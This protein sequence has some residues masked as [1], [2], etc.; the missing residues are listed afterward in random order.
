[1]RLTRYRFGEFELDPAS[2]ELRRDGALLQVPLKSLECLAYLVEHRE[3]AVGRDELVSAV[4]GRADVSDTV[5]TQTMRRAR[6]AL[7]DAGNR[8]TVVRTVPGF[9]Y[10][11]VATTEVVEGGRPHPAVVPAADPAPI[12]YEPAAERVLPAPK[13]ATAHHPAPE[14]RGRGRRYGALAGGLFLIAAVVAAVAWWFVAGNH[15]TGAGAQADDGLVMVM[16]V[17]VEPADR[18][19]SWVRLGAMEYAA[20]R[21]RGAA[22]KVTPTEQ[23]L[24]L[25]AASKE[26]G[27]EP[28][29]GSQM[30]DAALREL[31]ASSGA[32]WLLVPRAQQEGGH[33]RVQLRALDRA[34]DVRVEARGDS[35]LRAMAVATD[36]WLRRIG[37][38][39]P[40]SRE[41]TPLQE[42]LQRIDAELDAGQLEA[43]R[44]QITAA[45]DRE[46]GSAPMLVREGQLEYRAGRIDEAKALFERALAMDADAND[47]PTRAKGL[48]GMGA[49]ALRQARLSDAEASYTQALDVLR[50]AGADAGMLGN[51]YNGRGVARV[52]R[53]DM[54]GAVGDLGLARVAMQQN[55]DVVSAAMVGSNLGRIEAIRNHLPQAIQEYDSAIAVFERYQ[56]RDYLAATLAAKASAQL[57]L[58]QNAAAADTMER[59][60]PLMPAIEDETLLKVLTTTRARISIQM[61]R[62]DD[63]GTTLRALWNRNDEDRD[64]NL[65]GLAMDLA[66][67]RGD[68]NRAATLAQRVPASSMPTSEGVIM[69]AAQAA[70][71]ENTARAWRALLSSAPPVSGTVPGL[72]GS[73]ADAVVERRFGSREQALVAAS[74]AVALANR[75][76]SPDDRVRT[77]VLRA[78]ILL[79]SGQTQTATAVLGELDAYAAVDYRVAWLAWTLYRRSGDSAM[80]A[81][82][83]QRMDALRGQ[84]DANIEPVL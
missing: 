11:W 13:P 58:V 9:G 84:R 16:P 72:A 71:A 32:H 44:E 28:G 19:F 33:W 21:L 31:L 30:S 23:T 1:M 82:A 51:A 48:M 83:R 18:E 3:R 46:R 47:A 63:A 25:S 55:G 50:D 26:G 69:T 24:H 34:S 75:D 62:L 81:Q 6:K 27:G 53:G 8:Q 76:G 64:G 74:A 68:R 38:A 10:R 2:R 65:A 36:A 56:V 77:S 35:P 73:F 61:G 49:V 20:D 40:G 37:H 17:S 41:P 7:D 29:A 60:R 79:D 54:E 67:A 5:I 70:G 57:A 15:Q 52:Q 80:T 39:N 78:L 59:V 45:P 43:A 12:A 22:L 42:R 14:T 66:L 4:W